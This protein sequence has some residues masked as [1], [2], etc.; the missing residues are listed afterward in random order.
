MIKALIG[1]GGHAREVQAQMV[2]RIHNNGALS[3]MELEN[4]EG[5]S[6]RDILQLIL[7][8]YKKFIKNND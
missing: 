1:N 4:R 3:G 2:Y 8:D 5:H 7:N 6:R